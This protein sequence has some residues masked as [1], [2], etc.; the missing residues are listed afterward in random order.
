M[1]Q[2]HGAEVTQPKQGLQFSTGY[3]EIH[4]LELRHHRV[5]RLFD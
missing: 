4:N 1:L 3:L 5:I 2:S